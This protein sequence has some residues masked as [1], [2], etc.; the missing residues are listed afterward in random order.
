[1]F[2]GLRSTVINQGKGRALSEVEL[3]MPFVRVSA[4]HGSGFLATR[5]LVC[6]VLYVLFVL[7][8]FSFSVMTCLPFIENHS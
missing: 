7:I 5:C 2:P 8:F 4:S 1:M 3:I 6:F